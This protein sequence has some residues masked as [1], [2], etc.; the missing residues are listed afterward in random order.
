MKQKKIFILVKL[1][2]FNSFNLNPNSQFTK[3]NKFTYKII[4]KKIDNVVKKVT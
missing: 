3:F 1:N 2:I 4:T